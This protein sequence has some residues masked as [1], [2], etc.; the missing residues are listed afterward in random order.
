MHFGDVLLDNVAFEMRGSTGLPHLLPMVGFSMVSKGVPLY[1][2]FRFKYK[3]NGFLLKKVFKSQLWRRTTFSAFSTLPRSRSPR[4]SFGLF[5]DLG[6]MLL[7][8]VAL[9]MRAGPL[10]SDYLL[11]LFSFCCCCVFRN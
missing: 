6:D 3:G 11:R 7:S 9:D 4:C 8:N 1:V 5:V 10:A 2:Q